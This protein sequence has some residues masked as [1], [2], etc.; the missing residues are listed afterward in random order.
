MIVQT[1]RFLHHLVMAGDLNLRERLHRA[2][3]RKFS[4]LIHSFIETFGRLSYAD[5]PD[6]ISSADKLTWEKVAGMLHASTHAA[7]SL[8][9]GADMARLLLG[10]VV[11]GPEADLIWGTYQYQ[12]DDSGN[13]KMDTDDED[14]VQVLDD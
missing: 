5:C 7:H 1:I 14:I 11:E 6:C 2:P 9:A 10:L 12:P 4:G 13:G 3:M 8:L